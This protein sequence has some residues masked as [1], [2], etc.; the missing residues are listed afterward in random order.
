VVKPWRKSWRK[1][2]IMHLMPPPRVQPRVAAT[3]DDHPARSNLTNY[4]RLLPAS[5]LSCGQWRCLVLSLLSCGVCTAHITVSAFIE[6]VPVL[7]CAKGTIG[8]E[9]CTYHE[10]LDGITRDWSLVSDRSQ[11]L[12]RCTSWFWIALAMGAFAGGIIADLMGRRW[13]LLVGSIAMGSGS[14]VVMLSASVEMYLAA[15]ILVGI[16][17]GVLLVSTWVMMS[18]TCGHAVRAFGGGV[19]LVAYSAGMGFVAVAEWQVFTQW[20]SLYA[21]LTV[22]SMVPL[23]TAIC[24]HETIWWMHAQ[25]NIPEVEAMQQL[26]AAVS[27]ER[28]PNAPTITQNRKEQL[29]FV[30][31]G[32]FLPLVPYVIAGTAS[33]FLSSAVILDAWEVGSEG[34][35]T[36]IFAASV[37][38]ALCSIAWSIVFRC[39]RRRF[40]VG[41]WLILGTLAPMAIIAAAYKAKDRPFPELSSATA[42]SF[43]M[44]GSVG[45]IAALLLVAAELAPTVCLYTYEVTHELITMMARL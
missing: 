31:G 13:G 17:A 7:E 2:V 4:E 36:D 11:L 38:V 9:V 39:C 25:R 15:R 21:C 40:A 18:E 12:S 23:V 44:F 27:R 10:K 34:M 29:D 8:Y 5:N 19:F 45:N 1:S 33:G 16:G 37:G 41:L 24:S 14:S 22:M 30:C 35:R 3:M 42:A 6:R 32:G 28:L 43:A 20:R 26:Y